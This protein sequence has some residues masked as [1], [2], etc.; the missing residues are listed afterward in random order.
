MPHEAEA[1]RQEI[2]ATAQAMSRRGLSPQRSGNVS[3]RWGDE[4]L[5]TP[6]AIPYEAMRPADIVAVGLDGRIAQ[7]QRKPSTETPFHRAIYAARPDAQAIVHCHSPR[8]AALACARQPIPAFHYMVAVAGG[9][10]IRCSAY[11]T[12]G[13]DALAE[14]T[15]DALEGRRACLLANHG[16]VALGASLAAAL[17]LAAEVE[18][19]AGM[20][21]DLLAAGLKP[22]I[23]GED[24]MARVL[25]AFEGYGRPED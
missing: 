6:S 5:I 19:L 23:L 25:E 20:F 9:A 10:G 7:G 21:L 24:E 18:T 3:A 14:N 22:H 15:V 12:F 17:E 8:A 4:L 16:Q 1:L 2:V 13:T 11:A